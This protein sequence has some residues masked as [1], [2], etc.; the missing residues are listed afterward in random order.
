M[1]KYTSS[2][3]GNKPTFDRT[4]PNKTQVALVYD[5]LS[6]GEIEGLSD[7]LASVFLNDT[8]LIDKLANE[9]V[10]SRTTT[11][12]TTANNTTISSSVFGEIG[13]LSHNDL[14][15]LNLGPRLVLIEKGHSTTSTAS[16]TARQ[17]SVFAPLLLFV[18]WN[19]FCR[20]KDCAA[21]FPLFPTLRTATPGSSRRSHF[22]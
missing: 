19:L 3:F 2:P 17:C 20:R 22:L 21:L 15:G 4:S 14:T 11:V 8:P 5:I 6:E 18:H 12:N 10:K 1:A 7:G 13:A 16:A 9:I